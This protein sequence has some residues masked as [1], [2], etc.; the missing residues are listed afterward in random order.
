MTHIPWYYE[1]HFSMQTDFLNMKFNKSFDSSN[2]IPPNAIE[3][4]ISQ[5]ENG[6]LYRYGHIDGDSEVSKLEAA[7]GEYTG[8]KYVVAVN[9]CGSAMF[10][11]LKA[12]GIKPGEGVFTNAFTFTAVPSSIVHANAVPVYVECNDQYV[13]DLKDFKKQIADNPDVKYFILSHMRGHIAELDKIKAL[14]DENGIR[15]IEDC[16]H[17]LGKR[18]N[19]EDM[20]KSHFVGHHCEVACYSTQSHKILNSGEGG[21]I[22]TNDEKLAA[23]CI[24]AAGS[25]EGLYKKH[26]ARPM[27]DNLFESIKFDVPNFSLRMNNL[28]A[29]ILRPQVELID[30]RIASYKE[31]YERIIDILSPVEHI[32]IPAPV[33][34]AENVG[35]SLQFN[36]IDFDESDVAN[37][38]DNAAEKGVIIQVFGRNNN[39]RDFRNWQYSFKDMPAC[40]KTAKLISFACDLRLPMSFTLE[41]IEIIGTIITEVM[42]ETTAAIPSSKMTAAAG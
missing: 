12:M 20:D 26:L 34:N 3:N 17:G 36:L 22:A 30:E 41:D 13:I 28:T 35:D 33:D 16:A 27:D 40:D 1:W 8:H 2:T 21:F 10:I 32:H 25:Y 5:M 9:S 42:A 19:A 11:A 7:F 18:W 39:A 29:S 4:A 15:L 31:K 6:M 23:Y 24:L 38:I 14:C 37:F